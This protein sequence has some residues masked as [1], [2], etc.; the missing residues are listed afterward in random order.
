VC[1]VPVG[2]VLQVD[3]RA[4]TVIHINKFRVLDSGQAVV[5]SN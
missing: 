5:H 1:P 4:S 2:E 3:D